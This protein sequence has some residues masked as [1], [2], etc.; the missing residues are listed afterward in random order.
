MQTV[1]KYGAAADRRQ[2]VVLQVG[3]YA[4]GGG[5]ANYSCWELTKSK[6]R[7]LSTGINARQLTTCILTL[8]GGA[9]YTTHKAATDT[10]G[11]TPNYY[12]LLLLRLR[13]THSRNIYI[14][15]YMRNGLRYGRITELLVT[16]TGTREVRTDVLWYRQHTYNYLR[17][18]NGNVRFMYIYFNCS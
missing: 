1:S 13:N 18:F 3:D 11:Q 9:I 6:T 4:V 2:A 17:M 7:Q 8:A 14:Y 5:G 15:I 16:Q 10:D 12:L